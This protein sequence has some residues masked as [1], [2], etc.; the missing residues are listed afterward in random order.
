MA[1]AIEFPEPCPVS[2]DGMAPDGRTR[3]C[4]ACHRRVH[5]LAQYRA[6][7]IA[8]LFEG[9]ERVCGR[10]EIAP[11]GR[12]RSRAGGLLIAAM[13]AFPSLAGAETGT[14]IRITL[15]TGAG[16]ALAHNPNPDDTVASITVA[17]GGVSRTVKSAPQGDVIVGGLPPGRYR[18]DIKTK[19]AFEWSIPDVPVCA[20]MITPRQ[21]RDPRITVRIMGVMRHRASPPPPGYE[22]SESGQAE[23]GGMLS[24]PDT[25]PIAGATVTAIGADNTSPSAVSADD[26]SFVL[27]GLASGDYAVTIGGPGVIPET[28]AKATVLDQF[29][30]PLDRELC[31]AK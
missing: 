13:M 7:E 8:G 12:L 25:N 29:R 22:T 9:G 4:A 3:L 20:G 17:G 11:D 28:I 14:G 31:P 16:S 15:Y 23:I 30:L 5:D 10:A 2:W 24:T 21:T 6:D 27:A 26:G 1:N 19:S 18:I